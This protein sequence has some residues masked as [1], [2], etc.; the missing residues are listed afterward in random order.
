MGNTVPTG[1]SLGN[2]LDLRTHLQ[3]PGLTE[4]GLVKP[5]LT[6]QPRFLKTMQCRHKDGP[7]VL[8]IYVKWRQGVSL[9]K[10]A[11]DMRR[12]RACVTRRSMCNVLP[13]QRLIESIPGKKYA[14]AF[15]I[16]QYLAS[17]LYDRL[18]TRPFLK[19]VEKRWIAYQIL[20]GLDQCH[21]GG[22][23]SG[24]VPI[25]HG[26]IKSENVLLTSWNWV[27]LSD[28]A[29]FKPTFLPDN[30]P[31]GFYYFFD[32]PKDR[33][34]C[35]LAPERFYS[36]M[37]GRSASDKS[38]FSVA[39][40]EAMST[41]PTSPLSKAQ[42][43]PASLASV[44]PLPRTTPPSGP[45]A[46]S[47]MGASAGVLP[48]LQLNPAA[49]ASIPGLVG[50]EAP[51]GSLGSMGLAALPIPE[52][53]VPKVV[54]SA[55][56]ENASGGDRLDT[57]L[58]INTTNPA[59]TV[60]FNAAGGAGASVPSP[61]GTPAAK[62]HH[63]MGGLGPRSGQLTAAMDIFS[64]GCVIAE[65]FLD[66]EPLFDL[67]RLLGYRRGD[68]AAI[69]FVRD[70]LLRISDPAIRGMVSSMI[71]VDPAQRLSARD[72][73][74]R[75]SSEHKPRL[76]ATRCTSV[77]DMDD[78]DMAAAAAAAALAQGVVW[79][80]ADGDSSSSRDGDGKYPGRQSGGRDADIVP[81]NVFP[82]HFSGFMF[83][84][85]Q[86][87]VGDPAFLSADMKVLAICKCYG[88]IVRLVAG[89]TQGDPDGEAFFAAHLDLLRGEHLGKQKRARTAK[90]DLDGVTE[91]DDI[92]PEEEQRREK[93]DAKSGNSMSALD[94][95][96]ASLG[97]TLAN[98]IPHS[99]V[100][101]PHESHQEGPPMGASVYTAG[102]E[103]LRSDN[104]SNARSIPSRSSLAGH[105]REK[106]GLCIIL[107]LLCSCVQA[108]QGPE[109]RVTALHLIVRFSRFCDDVDNVE[110][111]DDGQSHVFRSSKVRLH[112]L[113]P[114]VVLCLR[115]SSA[116][117][118]AQAVL[119]LTALVEGVSA[120]LP[121]DANL[122]PD[123]IFPALL[124]FTAETDIM[125]R[126]AFVECIG[127]LALTSERFLDRVQALKQAK[128][129]G[130]NRDIPAENSEKGVLRTE[131]N[132]KVVANGPS[133]QGVASEAAAAAGARAGLV[134]GPNEEPQLS[135]ELIKIIAPSANSSEASLSEER[136]AER[137]AA[138]TTGGAAAA[139]AAMNKKGNFK[140]HGG[141]NFPSERSIFV[142]GSYDFELSRLRDLVSKI[143]ASL[144]GNSR[145]R[146]S[147]STPPPFGTIARV[148]YD[149]KAHTDR[150][151]RSLVKQTL[152]KCIAPLTCFFGKEKSNESLFPMMISFLNERDDWKLRAMF[153]QH[154]TDVITVDDAAA[155]V[156]FDAM[157]RTLLPCIEDGLRD[158]HEFVVER[159][160]ACLTTVV[161][162]L[163]G[164]KPFGGSHHD[165]VA[166]LLDA[167]VPFLVHPCGAIQRRA[168]DF[169]SKLIVRLSRG[170]S[171]GK[172]DD[173]KS[174]HIQTLVLPKLQR[175]LMGALEL[176]A[177]VLG[178]LSEGIAFTNESLE[179]MSAKVASAIRA[180]LVEPVDRIV[181]QQALENPGSVIEAAE[182]QAPTEV[183][184]NESHHQPW[185]MHPM[186]E[187]SKLQGMSGFIKVAY[188]QR[189]AARG[190]HERS[191][192]A[193]RQ[194]E[195][196]QKMDSTSAHRRVKRMLHLY[197]HRIDVALP[198]HSLIIPDQRLCR[199]HYFQEAAAAST[200]QNL[201]YGRSSARTSTSTKDPRDGPHVVEF[202]MNGHHWPRSRES[203]EDNTRPHLFNGFLR[204]GWTDS[205]KAA[206]LLAARYGAREHS[207]TVAGRM[208][209]RRRQMH[210]QSALKVS[211][212]FLGFRFL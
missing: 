155:V 87:L 76:G 150:E 186:E 7:V 198:I 106:N 139:A 138:G 162:T 142:P 55:F 154:I 115:D 113:L 178:K 48:P 54:T 151:M 64:A 30:D 143:I 95:L 184:A 205:D 90:K 172:Y 137:V 187:M 33:Q 3:D 88:G 77:S 32:K 124:R 190:R 168:V 176:P 194:N 200:E 89:I 29:I 9:E 15:L 57:K 84:F 185:F 156:N 159:T 179:N 177:A 79:T 4:F 209:L 83:G 118:R 13:Y 56:F 39:E 135:A 8:K 210:N 45:R 14:S 116:R 11:R 23:G 202:D 126:L 25:Y 50:L 34:C 86:R 123:Y 183:A 101:L 173:D 144:V 44:P 102:Y 18:S 17:N 147:D 128:A 117:V 192:K 201:V 21:T 31:A 19:D 125:A 171:I 63:H 92:H 127:R 161:S 38:L 66:G 42:S 58:Q 180:I 204:D 96:M 140:R 26:D 133:Q 114:H 28:F 91:I 1:N 182:K 98:V 80:C 153:F 82:W 10:H 73:L 75:C 120:F 72:Y 211:P 49:P 129:F 16:R 6:V 93:V 107:E 112:R 67:A 12:L 71:S 157:C 65:L 206:W 36:P 27:M 141:S 158:L 68:D 70:A 74:I 166:G 130:E 145:P 196:L 111:L 165:S 104:D 131:R 195:D 134:D 47:N 160:F 62:E 181:L 41:P 170:A 189:R 167:V 146:T 188:A 109:C 100:E 46:A 132:G 175:F 148:R 119:A 203:Y 207:V 110:A 105:D 122:F 20:Q 51:P 78:L 99:D 174:G 164:T 97:E 149:A 208:A 103:R 40:G 22:G 108:V 136:E 35:Y 24:G 37:V 163:R 52:H 2:K 191:K 59:E 60:D 5:L 199:S 169:L 193:V 85:I 152:L 43:S 81:V 69:S 53:L 94:G 61:T 212:Q 121:T 197:N